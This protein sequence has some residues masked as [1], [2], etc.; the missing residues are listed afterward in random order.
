M[1]SCCRRIGP[2]A[3]AVLV[4]VLY[5]N[6]LLFPTEPPP[7]DPDVAALASQFVAA[8]DAE[9]AAEIQISSVGA[10][11]RDRDTTFWSFFTDKFGSN[12]N[13]P[14]MWN[15]LPMMGFGLP[16]PMWNLGEKDAVVRAEE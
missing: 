3:L 9:H 14:Y 5:G 4:A 2:A 15:A 12:P 8:I 7:S 1:S 13:T 11:K 16:S 6:N 10:L